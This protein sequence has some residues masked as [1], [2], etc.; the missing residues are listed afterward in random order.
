MIVD[1][2]QLIKLL[3][4]ANIHTKGIDKGKRI[5]YINDALLIGENGKLTI[6]ACP[7]DNKLYYKL[8]MNIK[9]TEREVIPVSDIK[10]FIKFL[11]TFDDEVEIKYEN[12]E[13]S[14]FDGKVI[15]NCNTNNS[16]HAVAGMKN[17]ENK[18]W[19]NG[20]YYG[21]G[22]NEIYND[23]IV[24]INSNYLSKAIKKTCDSIE[25]YNLSIGVLDNTFALRAKDD[26]IGDIV[27]I[28]SA[29]I[30]G[31]DAY[32]NYSVGIDH[33]FNFF[34]EDVTLYM[35]KD[36]PI[37]ACADDQIVVLFTTTK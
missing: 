17:A 22:T 14:V 31:L 3:K 23:T 27:N 10:R 33:V 8:K 24:N 21:F 20:E 4:F 19:Y 28:L 6:E 12:N 11:N 32:S 35:K 29:E 18:L 26:D 16:I 25:K 13:I 9:N 34:E 37:I 36:Q 15:A 1:A 5:E 7:L 2:K 30:N